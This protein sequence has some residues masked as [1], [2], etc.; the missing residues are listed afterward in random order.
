M[1]HHTA[2][3]ALGSDRIH[4]IACIASLRDGDEEPQQQG[5]DT[6]ILRFMGAAI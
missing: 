2:Y 4:F 6:S 5:P 1:G 3:V